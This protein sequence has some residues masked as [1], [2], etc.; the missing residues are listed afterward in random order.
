[1]GENSYRFLN[2]IEEKKKKGFLRKKGEFILSVYDY[3]FDRNN[4]CYKRSR[5]KRHM[6]I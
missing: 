5:Y 3:N 4:R 2:N 1:M 6:V